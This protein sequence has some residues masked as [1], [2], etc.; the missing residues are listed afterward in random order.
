MIFRRQKNAKSG[1][2][3]A[4]MRYIPLPDSSVGL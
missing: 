4:K 2:E 1:Y 3:H